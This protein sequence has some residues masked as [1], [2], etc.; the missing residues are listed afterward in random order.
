MA[1]VSR[2]NIYAKEQ[3]VPIISGQTHHDVSTLHGHAERRVVGGEAPGAADKRGGRGRGEG[4]G[5]DGESG[6]EG[7]SGLHLGGYFC[8]WWTSK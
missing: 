7:E 6:N 4:I 8:N 3:S 5:R 1:I 2:P